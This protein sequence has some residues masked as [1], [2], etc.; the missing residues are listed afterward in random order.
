MLEPSKIFLLGEG[1]KVQMGL[2]RDLKLVDYRET[3]HEDALKDIVSK[4]Y[5]HVV[6]LPLEEWYKYQLALNSIYYM[7]V[8]SGDED[9][10]EFYS[11][12]R[13]KSDLFVL[14]YDIMDSM[15]ENS[16][17]TQSYIC[18]FNYAN[19]LN[20]KHDQSNG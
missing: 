5:N 12:Y 1:I 6:I 14:T 19:L 8:L 13:V 7:P 3:P 16:R 18:G 11:S 15:Y 20:K 17:S 9:A 4:M 10:S 2:I